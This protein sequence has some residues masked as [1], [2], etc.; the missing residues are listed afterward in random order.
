MAVAIQMTEHSGDPMCGPGKETNKNTSS[1]EVKS[2]SL[3][4]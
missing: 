4:I 3:E 1:S 2:T